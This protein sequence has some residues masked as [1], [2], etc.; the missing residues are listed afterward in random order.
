MRSH[1]IDHDMKSPSRPWLRDA[2]ACL[3]IFLGG[4]GRLEVCQISTE[5]KHM[6]LGT[7]VSFL[8][9]VF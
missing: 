7:N 1:K 4:V 6:P 8:R 2:F 5:L 3:S 9:T